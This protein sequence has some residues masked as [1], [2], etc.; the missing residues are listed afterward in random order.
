MARLLL[1]FTLVPLVELYLLLY[2]G[3]LISF[4]P[5]VGI[6]VLTGILGGALARLEGLRVLRRWQR[7]LAEHR[8]PEDG[9]SDGL[10]VLIGGVLLITPGILTDLSG[11]L[12]LLPPTRRWL[13]RQLR[14]R[15]ERAQAQGRVQSFSFGFPGGMAAPVGPAASRRRPAGIG[16]PVG[17][18]GG[19]AS[20]L[21]IDAVGEEVE[22]D[23][24][25]PAAP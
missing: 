14:R 23:L 16:R 12:L 4:W 21:V 19:R 25:E 8:V 11:L 7:A 9:V 13:S 6:V 20:E 5:T 15:M 18:G 22:P 10:L 1:L 3:S 2:V 24:P 17:G